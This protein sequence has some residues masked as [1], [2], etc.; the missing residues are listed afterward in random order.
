M[1]CG[2]SEGDI[3]V[4]HVEYLP[5]TEPLLRTYER[6][7]DSGPVVPVELP[8]GVGVWAVTTHAAAREVL[9]ADN[10]MF[11]K[12]PS[13]W[14]AL[15]TGMV[16][17]DWPI[18]PIITGEHLLIQEGAAHKRLRRL[19]SSA[20]TPPRVE[21]LRPRIEQI[22]RALLDDIVEGCAGECSGSGSRVHRA[23]TDGRH[24]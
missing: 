12:R 18:L 17:A 16:P 7:R 2:P 4:E 1:A 3:L 8:G 5:G 22:V 20:F 15:Q 14:A 24:L 21:G 23:T 11:G 13:H 9:A 10:K 6:L 19:L